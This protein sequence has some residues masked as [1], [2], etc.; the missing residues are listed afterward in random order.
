MESENTAVRGSVEDLGIT[1]LS[2]KT[3]R[4]AMVVS[5]VR[6]ETGEI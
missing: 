2:A 5:I 3:F 4:V 1:E 6:L